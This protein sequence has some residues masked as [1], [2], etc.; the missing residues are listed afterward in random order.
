MK[1]ACLCI[2]S[3]VILAAAGCIRKMPAKNLLSDNSHQEYDT[4]VKRDILCIMMAYPG[5]VTGVESVDGKV[6]IIMKSGN[7]I[8]YDDKMLK[9]SD[10]KMENC[11][12]QDMME[13]IYPLYGIKELMKNDFDPGRFR[14]Y[15]LLHDVYGNSSVQVQS[16]LKTIKTGCGYYQFNRNNKAADALCGALNEL[17]EIMAKRN[18]IRSVVLPSSGTFN[19]RYIA[20][21]RRLSP[22]SFGIAIDLARNKRD[23]WKWA[24]QSEGAKRLANY[25]HEVP[26]VFEKYNFIWGGKWSHFDIL[27]FEYRPEIIYKARFFGDNIES[28]KPWYGDVLSE[29]PDYRAYIEIIERALK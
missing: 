24:S 16:N 20:G 7:R 4:M 28:E 6:Y 25:P 21:T 8:L 19:Y 12:I 22:H 26:A 15:S 11:D 13:Q 14:V 1:K 3:I 18:D 17:S 2:L 29:K 27:H 9:N 10:E 5:Y 23:Y